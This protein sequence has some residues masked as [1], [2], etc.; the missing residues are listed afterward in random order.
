MSENGETV[1]TEK[2]T[3]ETFENFFG[4]I[5]KNL[6]ISHYS[7]FDHI[8]ENVKDPT[9]K[10]ILKYEKHP[11]ILAI[12][13]KCNRN[14]AF[15]FMDV[16]LKEIEIEIRPLKLTKSSQCS[17]IPTKI[18]KENSDIFSNFICESINNS[19]KIS[20]FPSRLKHANVKPLHEKFN[21]SLK[22]NYRPVN[23]LPVFSKVFERSVLSKYQVF[24]MTYFQNI[25]K[26]SEKDL[27]LN[28][29]S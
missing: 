6:N 16:N 26:A 12:R 28:N 4:N 21:K 9:L 18:I 22:E 27:V 8:I 25:S 17:D 24:L 23:I 11:S 3:G 13:T 10:A 19:I 14:D 1:R 15:S 20:I 7:D 2:E 29:F 5:V